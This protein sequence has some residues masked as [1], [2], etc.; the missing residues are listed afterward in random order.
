M[1]L[2]V[3]L[4]VKTPITKK[5]TGVFVRENGRNRE[6]TVKEVAEKFPDAV[7]DENEYKTNS[8]FS[9]NI[10]NNL[11]EMAKKLKSIM[12]AGSQKK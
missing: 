7:I 5:G 2:D 12:L 1:S 11:G 9:S 3:S 4:I 8:V 6:L 10:T